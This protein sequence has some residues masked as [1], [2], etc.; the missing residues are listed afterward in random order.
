MLRNTVD[1]QE[2]RNRQKYPKNNSFAYR[3][4]I[5]DNFSRS[6]DRQMY[7]LNLPTTGNHR[8][9][10]NDKIM[11]LYRGRF[12]GSR[13]DLIA[14]LAQNAMQ[15]LQNRRHDLINSSNRETT[16]SRASKT[17]VDRCY[18]TLFGFSAEL[19]ATLGMSELFITSSEPEV[20]KYG[21]GSSIA[22]QANLSTSLYRLVIEGTQEQIA[23]Y[24]LP[25]D[26]ILA[27]NNHLQYDPIAVWNAQFG[28]VGH[29]IWTAEEDV[30]TD[31]MVDV[32]CA[33]FL[34]H[35]IA[36]TQEY[37]LPAKPLDQELSQFKM[38]EADPWIQ[39]NDSFNTASDFEAESGFGDYLAGADDDWMYSC[40]QDWKPVHN[41]PRLPDYHESTAPTTGYSNTIFPD[42]SE[43]SVS[44]SS[45]QTT[46][47]SLK[48]SAGDSSTTWQILPKIRPE[49]C[50]TYLN[51]SNEIPRLVIET[52]APV[53]QTQIN[54]KR[55]NKKRSTKKGTTRRS[56]RK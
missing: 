51:S 26:T 44:T 18:N 9:L 7:H 30:L 53:E 17:L 46:G 19:N 47:T 42:T 40:N 14:E 2:I 37:L 10:M 12:Q 3:W 13:T 39:N 45:D 38:L 4:R 5:L 1:V 20:K 6:I 32:A 49:D 28:S 24:L 11:Q 15:F 56:R 8:T 21:R 54:K 31:D 55:T 34:R 27:N 50:Q 16:L 22:T 23:F 41:L 36:T 48:K 35:L 29:V 25:A 52:A 43:P 33:D